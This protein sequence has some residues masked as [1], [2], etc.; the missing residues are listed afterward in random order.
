MQNG[1]DDE[2]GSCRDDG[3]DHL[4]HFVDEDPFV[5]VLEGHLTSVLLEVA[6][7]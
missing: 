5:D 3:A 6:E 7:G 2:V 4:L 1:G